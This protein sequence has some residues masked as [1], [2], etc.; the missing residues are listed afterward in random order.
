ME[1]KLIGDGA[2][3]SVICVTDLYLLFARDGLFKLKTC[4][5]S[6]EYIRQL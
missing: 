2:N 6:N 5:I 1:K 3:G 4:K